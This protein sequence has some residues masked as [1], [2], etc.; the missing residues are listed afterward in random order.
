MSLN[1]TTHL[2]DGTKIARLELF[3]CVAEKEKLAKQLWLLDD[4]EQRR[5][6]YETIVEQ[7]RIR[8]EK[9]GIGGQ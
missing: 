6:K 4:D 8:N 9:Y 2:V 7:I 5:K 1:R 3:K